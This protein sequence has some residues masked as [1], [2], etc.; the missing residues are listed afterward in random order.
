MHKDVA[1]CGRD[2]AWVAFLMV[3]EEG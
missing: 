2:K 1:D 3:A